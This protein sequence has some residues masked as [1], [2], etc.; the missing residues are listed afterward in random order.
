MRYKPKS[1][2]AL[3]VRGLP[4]KIEWSWRH[5]GLAKTVGELP[6]VRPWPENVVVTTL[7]GPQRAAPSSHCNQHLVC[8]GWAIGLIPSTATCQS[9]TRLATGHPVGSC[10]R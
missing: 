3:H 6:K 10:H 9:R 7:N 8:T 2:A 4:D 5:W 1:I